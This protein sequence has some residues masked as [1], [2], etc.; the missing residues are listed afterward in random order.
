MATVH[1]KRRCIEREL[2]LRLRVYPG[3]IAAGK[4]SIDTANREVDLMREI[5]ADYQKQEA[6]AKP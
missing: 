6:T 5:L 2:A 3:R 1:E 4:M